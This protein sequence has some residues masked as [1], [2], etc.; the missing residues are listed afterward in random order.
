LV[1]K[2]KP[3]IE[4]PRGGE[5]AADDCW[6]DGYHGD[7]EVYPSRRGCFVGDVA[8]EVIFGDPAV[9]YPLGEFPVDVTLGVAVGVNRGLI[10]VVIFCPTDLGTARNIESSLFTIIMQIAD[11]ERNI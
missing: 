1:S 6:L 8:P 2:G 11:N 3:G 9:E 5:L 7:M 4:R 10:Y